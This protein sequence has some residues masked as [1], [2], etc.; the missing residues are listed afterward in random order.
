MKNF[1]LVVCLF[2]CFGIGHS[3]LQ[4]QNRQKALKYYEKLIN[5]TSEAK[6]STWLFLKEIT[7]GK[8]IQE[9][10]ELRITTIKAL[11]DARDVA[12]KNKAYYGDESLK[13]TL[14]AYF[15]SCIYILGNDF[16]ILKKNES[17]ADQSFKSMESFVLGKEKAYNTIKQSTEK[18]IKK[19]RSFSKQYKIGPAPSAGDK[20]FNS[21]EKNSKP[22]KY[23]NQI[24][25]VFFKVYKQEMIAWASLKKDDDATFRKH[26]ATLGVYVNEGLKELEKIK[27]FN[28]DDN[29]LLTATKELFLYYKSEADKSF[30]KMFGFIPKKQAYISAKKAIETIP[31]EKQTNADINTY[32]SAANTY[33]KAVRSYNNLSGTCKKQRK[34]NLNLWHLR[35]NNFFEF[36]LK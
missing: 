36:H 23:Y 18:L 27:P 5:P 19:Q 30:P 17:S 11:S 25:L 16:V 10:E 33:N 22:M 31:E 32:N 14:L 13:S 2:I 4:A 15:D 8:T 9:T 34:H 29:S 28:D 20:T 26:T 12:A 7:Q 35:V 6:R 24:Y 1:T 3:S 21:I